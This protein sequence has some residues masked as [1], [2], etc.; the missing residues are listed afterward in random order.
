LETGGTVPRAEI[1]VHGFRVL[2]SGMSDIWADVVMG[3]VVA[4]L[5]ALF[6]KILK[7]WLDDRHW[8]REFRRDKESMDFYADGV[9]LTYGR[10]ARLYPFAIAGFM[11]FNASIMLVARVS[12]DYPPL[13]EPQYEW[14]TFL[15][16]LFLLGV[17]PWLILVHAYGVRHLVTPQGI[18]RRSPWSKPLFVTW[19]EVENASFS[20]LFD[21][22]VLRTS[23]GSVRVRRTLENIS[24]LEEMLWNNVPQNRWS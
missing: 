13:V 9:T 5:G 11:L 2:G 20:E 7:A 23:K 21:A 14:M 15:V 12:N 10:A 22:Y 17:L 8:E 16:M 24:Y 1:R 3:L 19:D 4:V 6:G 18:V